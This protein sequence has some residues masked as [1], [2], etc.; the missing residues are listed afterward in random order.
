MNQEAVK[1]LLIGVKSGEVPVEEAIDRLKSLPYLDL[2]FAVVDT[3][4]ALRQGF[5]EV[6]MGEGKEPRD[7]LGIIES[8]R[9][10]GNTILVTRVDIEKARA[11]R[12]QLPEMTYNERA[13]SLVLVEGEITIRGRGDI[14]VVSAGT[15]DIP[16]AEEAAVVCELMGNRTE[17][18]WDVGVAGIHRLMNHV[19]RLRSANVLVVAAGME[20][21]LPSVIGGI[22][23]RPVVAV[24]TSVGYGAGFGGLS[25]LLGMLNSCA[26]GV[27][28][29]NI[30]N[31]FGAGY[32]ASLINR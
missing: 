23:E 2:G 7:I 15:S 18:L 19:D 31:G 28:V 20:G 3:H 24:P 10:T 17:R 16:V 30:D 1:N 21:A 25:A 6:I 22:V 8:L 11:V 5:P 32:V 29:V 4:R 27:C 12:E 26:A 13:R 9:K 14:M